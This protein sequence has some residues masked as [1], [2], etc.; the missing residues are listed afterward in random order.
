[1]AKKSDRECLAN[2]L[3]IYRA[4]AKKPLKVDRG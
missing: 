2:Y 3:A 1:L 4:L